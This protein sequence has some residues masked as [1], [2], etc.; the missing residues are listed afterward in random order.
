[1]TYGK[2]VE[3]QILILVFA[4]GLLAWWAFNEYKQDNPDD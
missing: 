2:T 3:E 4:V 1:M